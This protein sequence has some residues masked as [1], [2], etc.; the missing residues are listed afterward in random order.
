MPA[1]TLP[2][3]LPASPDWSHLWDEAVARLAPASPDP[4]G[5][6]PALVILAAVL[7]LPT[8]RRWGRTL[9]TIVHEAGHAGVGILVGRRFHG[10]VV[11]RDLGGHAVTS[12][13]PTG[14][15]RALTSWAGYPAPALLGLGLVA[16]ALAGW[17]G[18]VLGVAIVVLL[19]LLVMSR[20]LLTGVLVLLSG[21]AAL[22]LWWWGATWRDAAVAGLGLVLL[23]GAWDSLRDVAA[24]GDPNQDHGT[25]A[26]LTLLPA[27]FWLFTWF[28][29]DAAATAGAAWLVWQALAQA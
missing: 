22:A 16:A 10:F 7:A 28:L 13:K 17:G 6:W 4:H 15:G 3:A 5:L 18:A 14:P 23:L 21:L 19:G 25:L 24:S 20:S 2:V 29:A 27:G 26:S 11:G 12:G 8:L 1:A 9:T